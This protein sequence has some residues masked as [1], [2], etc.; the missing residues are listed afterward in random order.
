ML[1]GREGKKLSK[2]I[3]LPIYEKFD[4]VDPT[5]LD[6]NESEELELAKCEQSLLSL[7][8]KSQRR[9]RA[10]KVPPAGNRGFKSQ[11]RGVFEPVWL[12]RNR[13]GESI[14]PKWIQHIP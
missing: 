14:I 3:F 5:I 2:N 4:I 1:Y 6:A 7:A 9:V 11:L 12:S 8:I 10:M 13:K